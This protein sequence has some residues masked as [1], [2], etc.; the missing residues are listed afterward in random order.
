MKTVGVY[1]PETDDSQEVIKRE[2]HGQGDIYK[3]W[4][5]YE[6]GLNEVCYIPET[7]DNIY[8]HQAFLDI[9]NGQEEIAKELFDQVDW[10]HPET[11]FSEWDDDSE[12]DTCEA[13]SKIFWCYEKTE[14]PHCHSP[15]VYKSS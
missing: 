2:Y 14:C 11:L 10:Q 8:T 9:C 15:Y 1:H 7:S 12:I 4:D 5:A 6:R 13:C 3:N